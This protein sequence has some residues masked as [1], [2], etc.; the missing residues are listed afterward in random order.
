MRTRTRWDWFV[1]EVLC[2]VAAL[3]AVPVV[4]AVALALFGAV[5]YAARLGWEMAG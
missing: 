5:A 3:L 2:R 1:E 4:L